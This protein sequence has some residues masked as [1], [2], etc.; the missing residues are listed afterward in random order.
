[1][2][3]GVGGWVGWVGWVIVVLR[4][5]FELVWLVVIGPEVNA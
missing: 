4:T 5:F 2:I 3:Q 1:V